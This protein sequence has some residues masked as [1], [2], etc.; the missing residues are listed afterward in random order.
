MG[1]RDCV[2]AGYVMRDCVAAGYV[3]RDFVAAGHIN[4]DFVTYNRPLHV[5]SIYENISQIC[6]CCSKANSDLFLL[7]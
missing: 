2:A 3:M 7:L 5:T 1:L 4:R 6:S